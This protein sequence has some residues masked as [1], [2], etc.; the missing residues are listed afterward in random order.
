MGQDKMINNPKEKAIENKQ[1]S[2]LRSGNK[3]ATLDTIKEIRESGNIN[4]LPEIFEL[5][6]SSEDDQIISSSSELLNDLKTQ[7]AAELIISALKN[8]KYK[9]IR[10]FL[11]AACWQNGLKY[12]EEYQLFAKILIEEDYLTAI[13]AFTVIE[14]CL[15][16]LEDNQILKLLQTL[17]GNI[18]IIKDEKKILL[19]ELI[20]VIKNY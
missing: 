17:S 12:H 16:E 1:I 3:N 15:V 10:N 4:V 13:E 2:I 8:D 19:E 9:P 11:T 20:S 5:L 7:E 14:N 6:L 18:S